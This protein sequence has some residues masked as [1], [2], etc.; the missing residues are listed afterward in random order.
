M[1]IRDRYM[2]IK[3]A[4]SNINETSSMLIQE[5]NRL[6]LENNDL[7]SDIIMSKSSHKKEK[8]Q[9]IKQTKDKKLEQGKL[10]NQL[11]RLKSLYE[12]KKSEQAGKLRKMENKSK[13]F[14]GI[15]KH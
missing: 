12:Q 3:N 10:V 2:G 5:I 11:N 9:L 7:K 15:L 14:L 4:V 8:D 6:E 13:M 1:C